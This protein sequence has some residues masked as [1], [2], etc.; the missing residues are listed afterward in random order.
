MKKEYIESNIQTLFNTWSNIALLVGALFIISLGVLDYFATPANFGIFLFYRIITAVCFLILW[1]LKTR[2][3][4]SNTLQIAMVIIA[5]TVVSCMVALMIAKFGGHQ[6]PYFAGMIITATFVMGFIPFNLK[7][8]IFVSCLIYGIY[9]VPIFY[10][11]DI[12]N[13]AYFISANGFIISIIFIALL[14]RYLSQQRLNNELGLQYDL[15]QQKHKLETYSTQL[16]ELVAE[17][18]RDLTISEQRYRALFDNANDGI[19]VI[20][21]DGIIVNANRRFGELHGFERNALI[22]TNIRLLETETQDNK[23]GWVGRVFE[24]EVLVVETEHYKKD[25]SRILLEVSSKA[26]DIGG[27]LYIQSFHRDFTEKKRL[28][29]Q[30]FQ[31]QKMESIGVLAGGIAHDFNNILS[32]ILGHAELLH[33][34]SNLD[35]TG[36]RRARTI[37]NSARRAGTMITKLLSFAREGSFEIV[38]LNLNTIVKDTVELLERTMVKRNVTI[39]ALYDESI[40]PVSGDGNHLEQVIMNLMVNAA[41]AMSEGGTITVTTT[42]EDLQKGAAHVHPLLNPGRYVILNVSD[43]GTGI[44]DEI[45]N[46]IFDPFFTTKK[47]GK[48]TGLGLAMVYGIVKEH[49]GVILVKTRVGEGTAFE[50]YLPVSRGALPIVEKPRPTP[51]TGREKIL[52]V[53]DESDVLSFMKEVLE[54]QGY[55]VLATDNPVY[56]QETYQ[57]IADEISL[58][59]TDVVMPLVTGWELTKH[60]KLVKPSVKIIAISGYDIFHSE[61]ADKEVDA[62]IKKPFTAIYLLS[63]VRRVLDSAGSAAP[64][65]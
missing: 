27:Q 55:Q 10:Y 31:S 2:V 38:P 5:S 49:K 29:D 22:G 39:T 8:S 58:V 11:D 1:F 26:I 57:K 61:K 44:P 13:K 53:E 3:I 60:F 42:L 4:K 34:S 62:Y 15:E 37:E 48:G 23:K 24:G 59:I 16:E 17:R 14:T 28:Q 36:K 25:G 20:D 33:E 64:L 46:N 43:T 65:K 45:K 35:E 52:V 21:K 50:I 56:A 9:V 47:H 12:S 63:V 30:L 19:A 7:T 41:D 6:S 32:A 18:T 51:I 54:S 40:P